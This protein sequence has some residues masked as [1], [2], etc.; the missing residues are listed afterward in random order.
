[1]EHR[2]YDVAACVVRVLYMTTLFWSWHIAQS[3]NLLGRWR[4]VSGIVSKAFCYPLT[5][6]MAFLKEPPKL[7]PSEI[8]GRIEVEVEVTFR[9]TVSQVVCVGA[10][11]PFGPMTTFYFLLSFA[12]QLL[13]S[14]FWGALSDERTGL[15]FVVQSISGQSRGG[16]VTK[17][18]CLIWDYWVP[19]PSPLTTCR[20]YDGSILTRL[21][22]WKCNSKFTPNDGYVGLCNCP[23]QVFSHIPALFE[24]LY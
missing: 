24:S 7:S 16:L 13:C 10:G 6:K 15:Q 14:S 22:L 8:E 20:D 21:D 5:A 1:M 19:F 12:G 2:I 9:L 23:H 4:G 17:H 3:S 18:Y 11:H